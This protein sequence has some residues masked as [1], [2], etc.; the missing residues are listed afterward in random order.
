[1]KYMKT[2]RFSICSLVTP[3]PVLLLAWIGT[4]QFA[5]A[6][7]RTVGNLNDSGPGSLRNT[8]AASASGDT[9]NF[10]ASL[11]STITLTNGE[12]AI[13]VDLAITGPGAKS[14]TISGYGSRVFNV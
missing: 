8:I 12:L 2:S 14:L 13:A 7:I 11:A 9:I 10:D 5:G 4:A 3:L 1:M 6:T